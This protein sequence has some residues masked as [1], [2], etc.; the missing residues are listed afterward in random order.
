MSLAQLP[1]LWLRSGL[2]I[3]GHLVFPDALDEGC[4]ALLG[5][6]WGIR[7]RIRKSRTATYENMVRALSTRQPDGH[8]RHTKS[9][10]QYRTDDRTQLFHMHDHRRTP[11]EGGPL[12]SIVIIRTV[13][14]SA[15]KPLDMM[16]E[17]IRQEHN[18]QPH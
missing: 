4:H 7:S 15:N 2:K 17:F 10:G 16:S 3:N 11:G 12:L 6:V 18:G 8:R 13:E 1:A 14:M 9:F 5:Y